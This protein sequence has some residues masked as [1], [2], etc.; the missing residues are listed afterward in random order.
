M[1]EHKRLLITGVLTRNSI[2][3][4]V[5]A[6]AQALGASVILTGFGRTK[7]MTERAARALPQTPDV[8]DLDVTR[9]EHFEAL[10]EAVNVRWGGLDGALHAIAFAPADALGGRFLSAPHTSVEQ[11]MR[12]SAVSFRDLGVALA[13]VMDQGGGLVA[14]DLDA[15]IAW[16]MYDW[17]GVAKA[18]LESVSRYLA[19]YL[20]RSGIRVNLVSSG[21]VQTAAAS[22]FDDFPRLAEEWEKQSPLPWDSLDAGPVADA[23]CFLLSDCARGI[24]GEIVH[25]D[26][27]MH[28]IAAYG[29]AEAD[30]ASQASAAPAEYARHD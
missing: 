5:A 17:M 8:L 22:A 16:P 25:V 15:S 29:D 14:L 11:A 23:V 27:G 20:G 12:I 13:P 6:R 4:A 28:A 9:P 10:T 24:T 21:P 18:A 1:L 7:R 19:R 2:A 30:A 3:F 26:G